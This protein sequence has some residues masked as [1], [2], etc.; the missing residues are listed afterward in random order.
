M[1]YILV[2]NHKIRVL[3]PNHKIRVKYNLEIGFKWNIKIYGRLAEKK[4]GLAFNK[5]G[6]TLKKL[7]NVRED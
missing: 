6:L 5:Q 3:E 4:F 2:S 7:K 1:R